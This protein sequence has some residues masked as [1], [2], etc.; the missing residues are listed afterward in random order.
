MYTRMYIHTP[1][2]HIIS[3]MSCGLQLIPKELSRMFLSFPHGFLV[4]YL[5]KGSAAH[6]RTIYLLSFT[7]ISQIL[8]M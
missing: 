2:M 6:K 7:I 8:I 1:L 5:E 3:L 4:R